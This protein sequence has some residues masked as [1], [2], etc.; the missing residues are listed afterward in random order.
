MR[1]SAYSKAI[2]LMLSFLMIFSLT[3][4][5][6][7]ENTGRFLDHISPRSIFA[8]LAGIEI[9]EIAML[10]YVLTSASLSGQLDMI[11][12]M[13][14]R[15]STDLG[16]DLESEGISMEFF[17]SRASYY[18]SRNIRLIPS[19]LARNGE[20]IRYW[21][22]AVV[23]EEKTSGHKLVFFTEQEIKTGNLLS[24][25][26]MAD[27]RE[28]AEAIDI[29]RYLESERR[30]DELIRKAIKEGKHKII[31]NTYTP[32][33]SVYAFLDIVNRAISRDL[34][35][36]ITAGQLMVILDEN[37]KTAHPGSRGIYLPYEKGGISPA[38]IVHEA[39]AEAGFT[40]EECKVFKGMFEKYITYFFAGNVYTSGQL[41]EEMLAGMNDNEKRLLARAA[42]SSGF[43]DLTEY[44]R[45]RDYSDADLGN[46]EVN[47]E[48]GRRLYASLSMQADRKG[49]ATPDISTV[50]NF[51]RMSSKSLAGLLLPGESHIQHAIDV[52]R[53]ADMNIEADTLQQYQ[54]RKAIRMVPA[55]RNDLFKSVDSIHAVYRDSDG[56]TEMP[57]MFIGAHNA[58]PSKEGFMPSIVH[59]LALA[60]GYPPEKEKEMVDM[61]SPEKSVHMRPGGQA[62]VT[63][64]DLLKYVES[65]GKP[66]ALPQLPSEKLRQLS[67]LLRVTGRFKEAQLLSSLIK[68]GTIRVAKK[69]GVFKR[70]YG[71]SYEDEL[72]E[73]WILIAEDIAHADSVDLMPSV[74]KAL[75]TILKEEDISGTDDFSTI[76]E[77]I[78]D[79]LVTTLRVLRK[80]KEADLLGAIQAE[81][82]VLLLSRKGVNFKESR[83]IYYED[84]KAQKWFLLPDH[85][86]GDARATDAR[87]QLVQSAMKVVSDAFDLGEEERLKAERMVYPDMR[88]VLRLTKEED[89]AL[90]RLISALETYKEACAGAIKSGDLTELPVQS[91][92]LNDLIRQ[93]LLPENKYNVLGVIINTVTLGGFLVGGPAV[94]HHGDEDLYSLA[95]F[96]LING[97]LSPLTSYPELM[98]ADILDKSE[99]DLMLGAFTDRNNDI[100]RRF[101]NV[102]EMLRS[103]RRMNK[104]I[105][106]A[107][108]KGSV[109]RPLID[110]AGTLTQSAV[111]REKEYRELLNTVPI[112]IHVITPAG[113]IRDVN[114]F[115]G[116]MF[117]YDRSEMVGRPITDFVVPEQREEV[118]ERIKARAAGLSVPPRAKHR[119][120]VKKDGSRIIVDTSDTVVRD[121]N[122][123]TIEIRTA[124]KDVTALS[125]IRDRAQNEE[126]LH[127]KMLDSMPEGLVLYELARGADGAL[128]GLIFRYTN[129]AFEEISGRKSADIAGKEVTEVLPWMEEEALREWMLNAASDGRHA[130]AEKYSKALDRWFAIS[131]YSPAEGYLTVT[132]EDI[133]SRK[134]SELELAAFIEKTAGSG[135]N[136]MS[137]EQDFL[138]VLDRSFL[139]MVLFD[140]EGSVVNENL[141]ARDIFGVSSHQDIQGMN[142]FSDPNISEEALSHLKQGKT[143]RLSAYGF[144]VINAKG[145]YNTSKKGTMDVEC[146]IIPL[147]PAES[148]PMGYIMRIQDIARKKQAK[149]D[150]ARP[151]RVDM[152]SFIKEGK[153]DL[154]TPRQMALEI[155][156]VSAD[157]VALIFGDLEAGKKE[158][159]KTGFKGDIRHA[160]DRDHL[161]AMKESGELAEVDF[162]VNTTNEDIRDILRNIKTTVIDKDVLTDRNRLQRTIIEICA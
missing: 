68:S 87:N 6:F 104:A 136:I 129:R 107:N 99:A 133:T 139:G 71:A 19:V 78:I 94:S 159:A 60:L 62:T 9:K 61:F 154:L 18:E 153:I 23:S 117:G 120:Y 40:H 55:G 39:F 82:R 32:I 17:F 157:K 127:R 67:E 4:D 132:F 91:K 74:I 90:D 95:E 144:D 126:D 51:L 149:E 72:G 56:G 110:V 113:V 105:V 70:A 26:E 134:G 125:R 59:C 162:I 5:A 88:N 146:V 41:P 22:A 15:T 106:I 27:M 46:S 115:E 109:S 64:I 89:E 35:R 76:D 97:V 66:E 8:P 137:A 93:K 29:S 44:M 63:N 141:S 96:D 21:C 16:V 45:E 10:E 75:G 118:A 54:D 156:M 42:G 151:G 122:G 121:E 147:G 143:A 85:T 145:I 80:E 86:N 108:V 38:V 73:S 65:A 33:Y 101:S 57:Y 47:D 150:A 135:G 58:D 13:A 28:R 53:I 92:Q 11:A 130:S 114:D 102:I 52:L 31:D 123:E 98:D 25:I 7:G 50:K 119:F 155:Q 83:G 2:C 160:S 49:L 37:F 142:M 131:A 152:A 12:E 30:Q 14:D 79:G 124:L 100:T 111:L 161:I 69:E 116:A 103:I 43:V 3:G 128:R 77:S 158:L 34:A 24:R 140:S 48:T 138:R 84:S 81:G 1:I 36:T 20:E 112:G 148:G